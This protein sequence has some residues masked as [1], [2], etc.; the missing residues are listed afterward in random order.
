MPGRIA[1]KRLVPVEIDAGT[2]NQHELHADQLR[3]QLGF[4]PGRTSGVMTVA[5]YQDDG[6]GSTL[7]DSGRFTLYDAREANPTRSEY[8]LY[9]DHALFE[10][11][12]AGDL[13]V[14]SRSGD[15]L[16]AVIARSGTRVEAELMRLLTGGD[17]SALERFRY[18]DPAP[19]PANDSVAVAEALAPT[20]V[21]SSDYPDAV[22]AE[23]D[24]IVAVEGAIPPT[25]RMAALAWEA[26]DRVHGPLSVDL[27]LFHGLEAE[28]AIYFEAER[29]LESGRL[30]ALQAAGG[31]LGDITALVMR[32]LQARRSRR[33][34]SLQHHFSG[35]LRDE[36]IPFAAQ[37][38]TERGERPDFLIPGCDQYRDADYPAARL[39]LVGCKTTARERW[40]QLLNEAA[41]I[42][43]KCLLTV[44]EDL[45]AATVAAMQAAGVQVFLPAPI[46]TARYGTPLDSSL[47]TVAELVRELRAII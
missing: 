40:R 41:R 29:R 22:A 32:M 6:P 14:L 3:R 15:G 27:R 35:V 23:I 26:M 44:D 31:D 47:G 39:R 9:Y 18:V 34:Q 42:P 30:M 5:L 38:E 12:Q 45:S 24:R 21:T 36:E 2:S 33:G 43:E 37:C 16:F 11:A 7:V 13:L 10:A 28:S 17:V 19:L 25:R 46:I 4:P 1:F 20:P 8:R